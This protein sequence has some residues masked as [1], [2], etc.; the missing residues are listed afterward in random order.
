MHHF[1]YVYVVEYVIILNQVGTYFLVFYEMTVCCCFAD[2]R[3][4]LRCN[5]EPEEDAGPVALQ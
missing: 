2:R 3:K 1:S 4:H 5:R